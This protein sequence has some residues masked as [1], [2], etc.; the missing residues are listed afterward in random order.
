MG[1]PSI[2]IEFSSKGTSAIQ[3]SERGVV[4]V[5]LK[6]NVESIT[7]MQ[8]TSIADI[9]FT[10]ITERN[11]DYLKLVFSGIP[12][13]VHVVIIPTSSTDYTQALKKLKDL[14]WNY[15]TIPTIEKSDTLT[16]SAW[17]K[18][19][20]DNNKKTF[21]AILP[22]CNADHEGIINFTTGGITTADGKKYNANEY[23][24][25][26]AGALAGLSLARSFTYYKLNDIITADV[27][28]NPD[29]RIDSGELIIIFDGDEYKIGR[30]VNS[31]TTFVT[32]KGDDFSKIK[33]VEAMDLYRDDITQTFHDMYVGKIR[34]DYDGKQSFVAA[35]H[36]YHRSLMP[37]VLDSS[38]NHTAGIDIEAQ[39][40]FLISKGEEVSKMT[41]IQLAQGN[42]GS[43]VFLKAKIKFVDAMED[44]VYKVSI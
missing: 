26:I 7:Y 21:K 15:L 30:A 39:R 35:V 22:E 40:E 5:I 18:E 24:A 14:R 29:E 36:S 43:K 44:L 31:L 16:I 41:D 27:P 20:R 34:N 6:D 3:R 9:D 28:D 37:E 12:S 11:H 19:Q 13:M 25:R 33:I 42:T 2:S 38:Y 17:I 10:A 4:A 32:D 8:Y 23:C 1:L